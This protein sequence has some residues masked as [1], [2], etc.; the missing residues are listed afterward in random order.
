MA[1]ENKYVTY[2][3]YLL[4]VVALVLISYYIYTFFKSVKKA[5]GYTPDRE[6]GTNEEYSGNTNNV[7][8]ADITLWYASWCPACKSIMNDWKETKQKYDGKK[9][10]GCT[11]NFVEIDC[12]DNTNPIS[13]KSLNDY[14]IEGFPTVK[15][16]KDGQV[17]DLDAKPTKDTLETFLNSVV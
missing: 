10:N 7:E 14:N 1:F 15:I 2:G 11:I 12:S 3:L 16:I 13:T 4:L 9:I 8:S 6:N 17:I 5:N